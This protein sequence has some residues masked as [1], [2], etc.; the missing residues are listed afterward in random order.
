MQSF[1]TFFIEQT[2][3]LYHSSFRPRIGNFFKLTHV[4]PY[5]CGIDRLKQEKADNPKHKNA[6]YGYMYKIYADVSNPAIVEDY[7]NL[8]DPNTGGE[9]KKMHAWVDDLLKDPRVQNSKVTINKEIYPVDPKVRNSKMTIIGEKYT[10]ADRLENIQSHIE[11][12]TTIF[13][14]DTDVA[15]MK[16]FIN[17]FIY[18]LN[19]AGIKCLAY[20]NEVECEGQTCYI[21]LDPATTMKIVGRAKQIPLDDTPASK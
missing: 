9:F 18:V 21:I 14:A 17:Y 16:A 2:S 13:F 15:A 6:T 4:G 1:R 7:Y 19:A 5:E 20:K 12:G 8:P 10:V 3:E 11:N